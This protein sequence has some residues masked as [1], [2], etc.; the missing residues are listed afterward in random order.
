MANETPVT[1]R[2]GVRWWPAL[3]VLGLAAAALA[4]IGIGERSHIQAR[5]LLS[6]A[7][8]VVSALLLLV[9][10]LGFSR[11]RARLRLGILAVVILAG[12]TAA[13]LVRMRGVSGDLVPILEWREAAGE[14]LK[15]DG[16]KMKAA[17]LPEAPTSPPAVEGEGWPQFLGPNRDATLAGPKLA[18]DW[19]AAP[20]RLVWRRDVHPGWS[21]FA[22]AQGR[23]VTQEQLG[24]EELVTCYDAA[25]GAPLWSHGD[26]A[27]Y[28]TTIGGEG[29]RATPAIDGERV[30]TLGATGRLNCL[31]L[32]T[33][34]PVWS[35]D[36][37]QENQGKVPTWGL[38]VSPLVLGDWVVVSAGGA[39]QR[40]LVAYRKDTGEF[41]WGGGT[42]RAGY[43]SPSVHELCGVRQILIFNHA[44]VAGHSAETGQLLWSY[45]WSSSH[46]HVADPVPVA[47][48]RLVVSSGYGNAAELLQLIPATN[49]A[50]TPQRL[51]RSAK[52]KAKMT[53]FVHRDGCLYGLDDGVLVCLDAATGEQ[54]WRGS[55]YGH[56]QMILVGELL[57]LTAENGEVLLLEAK[58]EAVRE[59]GRFTAFQGKFW[60]SPALSGDRLWLRTD[61]QAACFRLP[62]EP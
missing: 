42:D 44:S 17:T 20:P 7:V 6:Y 12:L 28:A 8:L 56:G 62:L 19:Q 11:M 45:P 31:E 60:N 21:G 13:L 39:E 46:V 47:A 50:W 57:L 3:I 61:Q 5:N 54:K 24:P 26:A 9:W 16:G 22:V 48:D 36:I 23:A 34:K 25:T 49:G 43:S 30:F 51:W 10:C 2:P 27:R 4:W 59:L 14:R 38:S 58:P 37:M 52:L 29:P 15:D 40:S 35:K 33:G 41:A 53:N 18:R 55:R 32:A 1:R